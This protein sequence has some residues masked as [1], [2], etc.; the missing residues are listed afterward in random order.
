MKKERQNVQ[1][2][3]YVGRIADTMNFTSSL[4]FKGS[5]EKDKSI[6]PVLQDSYVFSVAIT[7]SDKWRS[8][9]K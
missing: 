6:L 1:E 7:L 2:R 8:K 3:I 9:I 4:G 5:G